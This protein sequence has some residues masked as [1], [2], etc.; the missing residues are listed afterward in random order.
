MKR[1][2]KIILFTLILLVCVSGCNGPDVCSFEKE[3]A[4]VSEAYR[5][6]D[7][8]LVAL[9]HELKS[10]ERVFGKPLDQHIYGAL[11]EA[12][13][14]VKRRKYEESRKFYLQTIDLAK[15]H[16]VDEAALQ[17][18]R[19]ALENIERRLDDDGPCKGAWDELLAFQVKVMLSRIIIPEVKFDPPATLIDAM[20]F[21]K[22]ASRDYDDPK[23]PLEKRGVSLVLRLREHDSGTRALADNE[24]PFAVPATDCD[25]PVLPPI[26]AR[27]ISL[28]DALR[29]V[30]DVTGY[31]FDIRGGL[32]MITPKH[33]ITE[34][35]IDSGY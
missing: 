34:I 25:A 33:D 10:I 1:V 11:N 24:D 22:Q 29:L 21:F 35:P 5:T 2:P 6:I 26:S 7:K 19:R 31:T 8:D 23:I 12:K 30:C 3:D 15:D 16:L 17:E 14:A 18:Y 4:S 9:Y 27:F 32:V 13:Q 20:D 28:Y